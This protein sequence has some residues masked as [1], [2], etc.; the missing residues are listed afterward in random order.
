LTTAL[1]AGFYRIIKKIDFN[2]VFS[3]SELFYFFKGKYLGKILTI[4]ALSFLI[5]LI[6][7]AFEKFLPSVTASLLSGVIAAAYSVYS[8]LFVVLFAFNPELESTEIFNL[9]FNLGTK[10]WLLV[11]GLLMVSGLIGAFGIIL[12]G[13]GLLFTISIIYLPPYFIYKDIIGFNE[14]SDIEQ[15]G[16]VESL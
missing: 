5:S 12:C 10:K 11:F 2:E 1:A 8:T 6:N 13:I 14:K 4:A 9:G 7:F 15:I 3:A 16:E